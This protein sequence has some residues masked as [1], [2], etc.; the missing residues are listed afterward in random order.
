[1]VLDQGRRHADQRP[2]FLAEEP[3]GV[4]QSFEVGRCG[5][6]QRCGV[7]ITAEQRRSHEVDAGIGRLC[8]KDGR[9][10]QFERRRVV[11]FGVRV[12]MLRVEGVE[13]ESR[14]VRCFH[15]VSWTRAAQ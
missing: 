10:Q 12:R 9:D 8:G 2:R 11:Q 4:N 15:G 3:G 14:V 6:L 13:N 5:V 1:V 7:G